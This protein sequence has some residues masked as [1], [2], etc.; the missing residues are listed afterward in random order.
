MSLLN[1]L[2]D[3]TDDNGKL[4]IAAVGLLVGVDE[5][6]PSFRN[7]LRETPDIAVPFTIGDAA[8]AY[9]QQRAYALLCS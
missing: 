7:Y 1:Q 4:K 5:P 2:R 8:R 9:L 3:G 6:G